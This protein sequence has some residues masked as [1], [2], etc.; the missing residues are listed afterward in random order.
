V[1]KDVC[2]DHGLP[3]DLSHDQRERMPGTCRRMSADGRSRAHIPGSI[4][5]DRHGANVGAIG[6]RGGTERARSHPQT[7]ATALAAR[8]RPVTRKIT[9]PRRRV[10]RAELV[11]AAAADTSRAPN[12]LERRC[13]A[14]P[15]K[16][17]HAVANGNLAL[18]KSVAL[19]SGGGLHQH[20]PVEAG[21]GAIHLQDSLHHYGCGAYRH[22][23]LGPG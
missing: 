21:R 16:I 10:L 18:S 12:A 6:A 15:R 3:T 2:K 23:F 20:Q 17:G 5:S 8:D 11:V 4:H 7:S 14:R 9:R 1:C 19:T 22:D 13:G